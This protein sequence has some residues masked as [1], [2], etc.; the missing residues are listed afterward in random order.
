MTERVIK[1]SQNSG[2]SDDDPEVLKKR[3]VTYI[4]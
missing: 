4:E 2:R 1:R 3:F